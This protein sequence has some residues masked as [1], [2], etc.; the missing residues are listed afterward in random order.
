[1]SKEVK[2]VVPTMKCQS[3]VAKI[4]SALKSSAPEV[5]CDVT[6]KEVR[7]TCPDSATPLALKK[8]IEAIGF[9]VTNMEVKNP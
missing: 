6:T 1:M 9:P 5:K 2:F 7:V 4:S 3:C 8:M